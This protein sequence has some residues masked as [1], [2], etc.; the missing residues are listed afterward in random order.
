MTQIPVVLPNP[1]PN[2]AVAREEIVRQSAEREEIAAEPARPLTVV[3]ADLVAK[4]SVLPAESRVRCVTCGGVSNVDLDS[5]PYC[6]A[7]ECV[8]EGPLPVATEA[9]PPTKEKSLM[10]V[11]TPAHVNG[12][13]ASKNGKKVVADAPP[14][15]DA[16]ASQKL[17]KKEN[18]NAPDPL[19]AT[20]SE[21]DLDASVADVH[22]LKGEGA[23]ALYELGR[24]VAHLRDTREW[25]LRT[26]ADQKGR[27]V[28]KWTS[29]EAFCNAELGMTPTTA[30]RL[31]ETSRAFTPEEVKLF[32]TRKLSLLLDAPPEHRDELKKKVEAGVSKKD[33]EKEVARVN[34][35][36]GHVKPG[37][38]QTSKATQ[39][40]AEKRRE[41]ADQKA[42]AATK[43][44]TVANILGTQTVKLFKKPASLKSLDWNALARARRIGDVPF[45]RLELSNDVTMYISIAATPAGDLVAKIVTQRNGE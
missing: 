43:T 38:G 40:S 23:M 4:Y 7:Q 29:F 36:E 42:S 32:G 35:V 24:R 25:K 44:I 20:K 34:R 6:G 5:C 19:L 9:H 39:A 18:R 2:L 17:V 14:A 15:S 33:L 1:S 37:S 21:A 12:K 22:R 11:P 31:A 28:P 41:L 13:S 26:V 8:D 16:A 3:L 27:P 45:G 10:L 30:L